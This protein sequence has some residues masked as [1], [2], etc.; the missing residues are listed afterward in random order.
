[1]NDLSLVFAKKGDKTVLKE[2][3]N[4]GCMKASRIL[5][6]EFIYLVT[7]GGGLVS[8]E[9]YN[10]KIVLE[11]DVKINILP[12]SN[13]KVYKT[14]NDKYAVFNSK[15]IL[16]KNAF[17]DYDNLSLIAY[18]NAK[19][20]Q[21]MDFYLKKNSKLIYIDGISSGYSKSGDDFKFNK[22]FLANNFFV[23][24]KL[25]FSDK[26]IL[27]DKVKSFGLYKEFKFNFFMLVYGFKTPKFDDIVSDDFIMASSRINDE[28]LVFRVL[29]NSEFKA[30][31]ELKK[32]KDGMFKV[33]KVS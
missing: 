12:Q 15:I 21:I 18:E 13:Q 8:G 16:G 27:D 14:Q 10:Q 28:I 6:D 23:D 33:D 22:L 25:I 17:L 1:M 11:N 2:Y 24:D 29:C 5:D 19:F 20:K 30:L 4:K 32:V 9:T 26:T 3:K 7:L 31:K